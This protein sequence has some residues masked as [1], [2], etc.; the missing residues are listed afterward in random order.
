[1]GG[2]MDK[3]VGEWTCGLMNGWGSAQ[4]AQS[5][6]MHFPVPF[7]AIASPSLSVPLRPRPFPSHFDPVPFRPIVIPSHCRLGLGLEEG[8]GR[9]GLGLT[10]RTGAQ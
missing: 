4:C 2:W 8:R 6:R 5:Y 7:R 9:S 1:M 3:W 10:L